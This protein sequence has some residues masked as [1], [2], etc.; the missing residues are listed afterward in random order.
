MI[1]DTKQSSKLSTRIQQLKRINGVNFSSF[2]IFSL[3][4]DDNSL[5]NVEYDKYFGR[6]PYGSI[7]QQYQNYYKSILVI[8]NKLI[9]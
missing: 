4:I 2:S 6:R 5:K 9:H 8:D 3:E 1:L 7:K